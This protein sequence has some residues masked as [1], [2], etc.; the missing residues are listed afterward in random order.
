MF[1]L[2]TAQTNKCSLFRY[3]CSLESVCIPSSLYWC[4]CSWPKAP[5]LSSEIITTGVLGLSGL[6]VVFGNNICDQIIEA[7]WTIYHL[8]AKSHRDCTSR[9]STYQHIP[10]QLLLFSLPLLVT[11]HENMLKLHTFIPL[12]SFKNSLQL[13]VSEHAPASHSTHLSVLVLTVYTVMFSYCLILFFCI[14]CI[15]VVEKWELVLSW[16]IW[17]NKDTIERLKITFVIKMFKPYFLIDPFCVVQWLKKNV[18]K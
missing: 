9:D 16:L 11:E 1:L 13:K 2:Y 8:R 4:W 18:L 14:C 7:Q 3:I 10:Q 15:T 17:L 12:L 5:E 6:F